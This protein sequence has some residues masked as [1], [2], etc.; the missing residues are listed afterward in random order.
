MKK[1]L[2][3][4][5]LLISIYAFGQ[6]DK[7]FKF[8]LSVNSGI[9]DNI[10]SSSSNT[11]TSV[12]T[13]YRKLEK[14]AFSYQISIFSD[15]PLSAQS[16]LRL[17]LGFSKTA[18]KTS[19]RKSSTAVPE[20]TI[21]EYTQFI[22]QHQDIVIPILYTQYLK[23]GASKFYFVSGLEPQI[24]INR[25][26]KFNQWFSDGGSN[27]KQE[28]DNSTDFRK[29]NLNL[30]FGIGYDVKISSR[31]TIFIQPTFDCNILGISNKANLNRRIYSIGLTVG[32]ILN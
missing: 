12:T 28:E 20:P 17:G 15:Y 13:T 22:W 3:L 2:I 24:K 21:P 19:K 16:K 26:V 1:L 29:V 10:I 14:P 31:S 7:K 9:S 6:E 11:P 30:T 4:S 32:M 23:N 25:T 5:L 8:G 18:Y 27:T